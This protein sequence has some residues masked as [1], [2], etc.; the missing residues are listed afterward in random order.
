[1][2]T[3]IKSYI[4]RF[5]HDRHQRLVLGSV[6]LVLA[7]MVTLVVY[8]QL[9][10]TGITMTNETYCGYEEHIHTDECYELTLICGLEESE[11]HTHTDECYEEQ[12]VLV[13]TL[14]EFEGHTHDDSCY[15][16]E[17][18]LTCTI[19]ESEGHV[20]TYECYETQLVLIC[21]LEEYEGHTHTDEC[22]EKTLICGMEE[23]THTVECL[24]DLNADVE[25]ATVW[26]ATLPA[27]TDDLRT[28]V[29][30][31]A[32]SQLGYTESTAN[33]TLAEDGTTHNG[34]TRYG[35][36]YGSS[37]A[38]W[39]SMF[40]AFCLDYA[41]IAD[42]FT[43]NAGAYAWSIELTNL[44]YYQ[45]V[46]SYSPLQGDVVFIDTD[47]DGK[48]DISAIVISVDET[49][50]TITVI[51]G[52]Y[53]ITDSEG[54]TTDTVSLVTYSTATTNEL[55]SLS[56]N[57]AEI[58][59]TILGYA[60]ISPE[61]VSEEETASEEIE[62]VVEEE[63]DLNE[64]VT[65]EEGS[66]EA[67]SELTEELTEEDSSVIEEPVE[68][69]DEPSTEITASEEE[70]GTEEGTTLL[71][72]TSTDYVTQVT[73]LYTLAMSLT[74]ADTSTAA[75]IWDSL[76]TI[77]E[78]IYA[79]EEAG[80]L[81]L[82]TEEY[83]NVNTLTDEVYYYFVET[84]RYDP[85]GVMTLEEEQ[86]TGSLTAT[87]YSSNLEDAA[88][89]EWNYDK[90]TYDDETFT[91]NFNVDFTGL[92]YAEIT[93]VKNNTFY[94][95][96]PSA[97]E[98]EKYITLD[99]SYT[100][101]DTS[102]N[103][104]FTFYYRYDSASD[105]YY[106][107]IVFDDDYVSGLSIDAT[108]DGYIN[109]YVDV[110]LE[111]VIVDKE[112]NTVT[113]G[114]GTATI[115]VGGSEIDTGGNENWYAD[116][117]LSKTASS[118]NA[119][120]HSITYTVTIYSEN[121][122]ED[123]IVLSDLMNIINNS[124]YANTDVTVS[125]VTVDSVT[126]YS[127][128]YSWNGV[129]NPTQQ[130]ENTD[131]TV[132]IGSDNS[133]TITLNKL[134][135]EDSNNTNEYVIGDAY[136]IKY[137][138]Y[139]N[140][141]SAEYNSSIINSATA[142][143]ET[144]GGDLTDADSVS[145]TATGHIATKNGS[146]NSS[147]ET[148]TW[149][150]TLNSSGSNIAGYV[151]TDKYLAEALNNAV[152]ITYSNGTVADGYTINYNSDNTIASITFND[153]GSGNYNTYIITYTTSSGA[154]L[155]ESAQT[156]TNEV[157]IDN[158]SGT[159]VGEAE[160]GVWV[161]A[162][163]S[164]A[165]SVTAGDVAADNST[166]TAYRT[167]TWQTTITVPSGGI[168]S[169]T[170]IE[171]YLGTYGGDASM[172]QWSTP[173]QW[174]NYAQITDFFGRYASGITI[175]DSSGNVET[176]DS[177]DY[178]L[179]AYDW[180]I[181]DWV[182]YSDLTTNS[183]NYEGHYFVAYKI[184]FTNDVSYDGTIN[185]SYSTTS[186]ISDVYYSGS[187]SHTYYNSVVINNLK[188][189]ASYTEY[190]RVYKTDGSDK[191]DDTIVEID[192]DGTLTWK[193]YLYIEAGSDDTYTVTDT[194][195]SG[196]TLESIKVSFKDNSDYADLT[197][198]N[199]TISGNLIYNTNGAITGIVS[200]QDVVLTITPE[201]YSWIVS[202]GGY[203]IITYTVTIDNFS[204]NTAAAT[205]YL[206][207][208]TNKVIVT[209][210]TNNSADDEQ[211]QTPTYTV[212]ETG[213]G[214][215]TE[216]D[217][218][219]KSGEYE[220]TSGEI[221]YEVV[222][223]IDAEELNSG[224]A[225]TFTDV[226][227]TFANNDYGTII[228]LDYSSVEFYQLY[229]I[230]TDGTSY[231]YTDDDG[232][233]YIVT[234]LDAS[235]I[236][237]YTESDG[238]I[239]YYKMVKISI[240]WTYSEVDTGGGNIAHTITASI[241]DKKAILVEY[242]YQVA[243]M[244][245]ANEKLSITNTATLD[246]ETTTEGSDTYTNQEVYEDPKVSG[247][248]TSDGG[249]TLRKVD[250]N[251]YT[252]TIPDTKFA[253][254]KYDT[255]T[256]SWVQVT[257]DDYDYYYPTSS[258]TKTQ[259]TELGY[260][261][262][263][264]SDN[265]L[266]TDSDGILTITKNYVNGSGAV[267]GTYS[268]YEPYTMYYVVEVEAGTGYALTEANKIYFYWSEGTN[269]SF[270]NYPSGWDYSN[271]AYDLNLQ[272]RSVYVENAPITTFT[273]NKVSSSDNSTTIPGATFALYVYK[274]TDSEGKDIW[275]KIGTYTTDKNGQISI[276]YDEELYSFN[277]AYKLIEVTTADGYNIAWEDVT[278]FYFWWSSDDNY[279]Y[280][281]NTPSGWGD[282]SSAKYS[283]VYD[284]SHESTTV[285]ATNTETS[286]T[287]EVTKVWID[288]NGN[289]EDDSNYTA[290]VQL[291]Y[292]LMDENGNILDLSSATSATELITLTTTTGTTAN[293]TVALYSLANASSYTI[294]NG[295][296]KTD[297]QGNGT[298]E[299]N[300]YYWYTIYLNTSNFLS[301]VYND[302]YSDAYVEVVMT[303]A[304][305]PS[306]MQLVVQY[307]SWSKSFTVP[308]SSSTTTGNTTTV[309]FSASDIISAFESAGYTTE[310]AAKAAISSICLNF[311]N[312]Q[313]ESAP[314]VSFE[315]VASAS[316]VYTNSISG[317]IDSY[318][319][320]WVWVAGSGAASYEAQSG[321]VVAV[322][323]TCSTS[324]DILVGIQFDPTPGNN[325]DEVSYYKSVTVSAGSGTV[326]VPVADM[327]DGNSN[328]I[329]NA[330]WSEYGQTYV[331]TYNSSF[332]GTISSMSVLVPASNETTAQT[333]YVVDSDE[334]EKTIDTWMTYFGGNEKVQAALRNSE[335]VI[336]I[337]YECNAIPSWVNVGVQYTTNGYESDLYPIK[338]LISVGGSYV[339]IPVT[340]ILGYSVSD[341][342]LD[343][344]NLVVV[345]GETDGDL[346]IKSVKVLLPYSLTESVSGTVVSTNYSVTLYD[347]DFP[348]TVT[349]NNGGT[350]GESAWN[351]ISSGATEPTYSYS[352][353]DDT[354]GKNNLF[355]GY[356]FL[357][358]IFADLASEVQITVSNVDDATLLSKLQLIIQGDKSAGTEG[359]AA[360]ATVTPTKDPVLNADGSYTLTYSTEAILAAL[361][362]FSENYTT[363]AAVFADY[364]ALI[365]AVS[366]SD[367]FSAT[368]TDLKVVSGTIN[369][370]SDTYTLSSLVGYEYGAP[371]TDSTHTSGYVFT[372]DQSNDWTVAVANL[373]LTMTISG[374]TYDIYYYFVET[375]YVGGSVAYT[376]TYSQREGENGGGEIVITNV[377]TTYVL[378]S[379]GV[380]V[381]YQKLYEFGVMLI[382]LALFGAGAYRNISHIRNILVREPRVEKV[383]H[384][385][386]RDQRP[387]DVRFRK[388]VIP[389]TIRKGDTRAG[390]DE[391]G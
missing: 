2:G 66:S 93:G 185:L 148:I 191:K 339:A 112:D 348:S 24:V 194:L 31:I 28:D 13:C 105:S 136:V 21:E 94:L 314:M 358:A 382:L 87:S 290:T 62:E 69:S 385:C 225:L 321:A 171:D 169:G 155:G 190:E 234:N 114:T 292:Y 242:S 7:I 184:T 333:Y 26:E 179:S 34:Y 210:G 362:S 181:K 295:V 75:T 115:E 152:T 283:V 23:H 122:T 203:I 89:V 64:E 383:P 196:V 249:I 70:I 209:W 146:Y 316:E 5:R 95:Y 391:A 129:G 285:T 76:M 318:S 389:R 218:V 281:P 84:V 193:V 363:A 8:W 74:S 311:N 72:S 336:Y 361:R 349:I 10:Y 118:Y 228:S 168:T 270:S 261:N 350:Y 30:N 275:V 237:K 57:A 162:S 46:E 315:V 159:T 376:T 141:E 47:S 6:L 149:T 195:P 365:M 352:S 158:G 219:S 221:N 215:S 255:S 173:D 186:N 71:T 296:E 272:T 123:K 83:D 346:T 229:K 134:N 58:T 267:L 231:T 213:G 244:S 380:V 355:T 14:E 40:V 340:D 19:E 254:Y 232:D 250:E 51:Q 359:Y 88:S 63:T 293:T 20:H 304:S 98:V 327:T 302:D 322:D 319:N 201:V 124:T 220:G 323:Y 32:Y 42:E 381:D 245:G 67:D 45:T 53:A 174:F 356:G 200:G 176:I 236:Y 332:A 342:N 274:E 307:D 109:F 239:T 287:I 170:E 29:V 49:A 25:D 104:A 253:L 300:Y 113:F 271:T 233:T 297:N 373:P 166:S 317:T 187:T 310:D 277:R 294:L 266:T 265:Y 370:A 167:L 65:V 68:T 79:E 11:G 208:Y 337:E 132:E 4:D 188:T 246:G 56:A 119:K 192:D 117:T 360:I 156:V 357:N 248:L 92:T 90:I 38:D 121:G 366:G 309:R 48:A 54:T 157:V 16:E 240:A 91:I 216:H 77:W 97:Y 36:W 344:Y 204:K 312:G 102:G 164:V 345:Q 335:A 211:T 107:E 138:V 268:W 143:T 377:A 347:P 214:G 375:S 131:Y 199:G 384:G 86:G 329:S 161:P 18:N 251:N 378:P 137:T 299:Y 202:N 264:D 182:S 33:Y 96:L 197:I 331:Y 279:T 371:Y 80:T 354:E 140:N 153:T 35:A 183:S 142:K 364:N 147:T 139:F 386:R 189:N 256:Y 206:S 320:S 127:E 301:A 172:Y 298:G 151:L 163:G 262:P 55:T 388:F 111:D 325:G 276:T 82:T 150:I 160:K 278:E 260:D 269:Y 351:L 353:V 135:G 78:Q 313:T 368:V 3:S 379:T 41:G 217:T 99:Y 1:M 374:K 324:G 81:T 133:L 387:R 59:P 145:V 44:G 128:Y 303:S 284:I 282:P 326:Y 9:R 288:E 224:N 257:K 212:V 50:S 235:D 110:S 43:Y 230:D 120:D 108:V 289:V 27:L 241:P 263:M 73:E 273:L 205:Y 60:N 125:N 85:Y 252:T 227:K 258:T 330:D 338:S 222:L 22:Y 369:T 144:S 223:N 286:T 101:Y 198:S 61:T 178:S 126:Y 177:T 238:S 52:N 17:G 180:T 280:A 130:T 334:T 207:P 116:L 100:G 165:K 39:E 259:I 308:L 37:Y 390:P 154:A 15:D 226:A 343:N 306:K 106:I 305:D 372:L 175:T 291:Y 341:Y 367:P 103:K 328:S 247:G 12:R 243:T